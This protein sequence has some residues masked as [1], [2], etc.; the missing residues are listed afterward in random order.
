[1]EKFALKVVSPDRVEFEGM[2]ESLVVPG[3]DGYLGVLAD[4]APLVT[5]LADGKLS[6]TQ[7]GKSQHFHLSGG[8]FLEVSRNQAVVLTQSIESI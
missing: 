6:L 8:G 7:E 4:H 5:P 1:M 3:E 2:I